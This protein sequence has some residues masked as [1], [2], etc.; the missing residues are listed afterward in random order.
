MTASTLKKLDDHLWYLPERLVVLS[1]FSD[2]L[3]VHEKQAKATAL[4]RYERKDISFFNELLF[5]AVSETI[6]LK[7]LVG[8]D[9]RQLF[10]LLNFKVSFLRKPARLWPDDSK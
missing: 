3:S 4:L 5:P 7:D 8:V 10:N 2:K 9:S 6:Q 1:R